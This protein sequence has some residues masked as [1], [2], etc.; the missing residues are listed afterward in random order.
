MFTYEKLRA[1]NQAFAGT[2]GVSE[3]NRCECFAP[4]FQDTT[5][6]RVEVARQQNGDPAPMHL[7]FGL[8]DDWV[9]ERNE[10]GEIVAVQD[11]V[12]SGFVRDGVFYTREE[13]AAFTRSH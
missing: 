13:A 2:G 9:S 11:S 3:N 10:V 4:A 12:V 5:T 8:P 1:E 7:L 6:G